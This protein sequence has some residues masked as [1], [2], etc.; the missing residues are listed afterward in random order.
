MKKAAIITLYGNSNFG[1][2]L[3]NYAVQEVLKKYDFMVENIINMPCLNNRKDIYKNFIYFYLN[4]IKKMMKDFVQQKKHVKEVRERETNFLKFNQ[5]INN[6]RSFFSFVR[7]SKFLKYDYY[8]VGSDQIWNPKLG[9]LTDLDLLTFTNKKKIAFGASFGIDSI[10]YEFQNKT[11][12]ALMSFNAISVREE[13]GK[14]IIEELTNRKDIEVIVDP[15][16]LL[17]VE[18]WNHVLKKPIMLDTQKYILCYFLGNIPK[19]REMLIKKYAKKTN[20]K[21]I[22]VLDPN[23]KYYSCGPSEFLYLEKNA[24]MICTDSFHSC[25]FA[26]L[27]HRP[28]VVFNREGENINMNSRIVTLLNKFNLENRL[29]KNEVDLENYSKIDYNKVEEILKIERNKVEDFLN[30]NIK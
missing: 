14:K 24:F 23:N 25:V 22:N 26:I 9:G 27:F 8:F 4:S 18:E 7:L 2:K 3:Q 29:Y 30:R 10:P 11:R 6:T 12:Q 19:E 5:L 21:I 20:C 15:T 28:F 13:K 17:T 1:N 16:M